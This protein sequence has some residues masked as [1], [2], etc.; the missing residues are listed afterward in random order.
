MMRAL[1]VLAS[2]EKMQPSDEPSLLPGYV[3][4]KGLERV[5]VSYDALSDVDQDGDGDPHTQHTT[6]L[7]SRA[8]LVVPHVEDMV[9]AM[10]SCKGTTCTSDSHEFR[11]G[12]RPTNGE[13]MLY[14]LEIVERPPC[15]RTP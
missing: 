7:V 14:R 9:Q 10:K 15:P 5:V 8:E 4:A 2:Y 1:C 12:L 6:D 3:P 13:L 11:F